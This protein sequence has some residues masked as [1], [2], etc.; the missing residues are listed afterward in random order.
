MT[1]GREGEDG[2]NSPNLGISGEAVIEEE[3]QGRSPTPAPGNDFP[4]ITKRK[5]GTFWRRKSSLGFGS[6]IGVSPQT[7]VNGHEITNGATSGGDSINNARYN[8]LNGGESGTNGIYDG[9]ART[10]GQRNGNISPDAEKAPFRSWSPPPQLPDFIGGGD[11]LG[12]ED[13]FKD[14]H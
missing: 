11:G 5:S 7:G 12:G 1:F 14:I 9:A 3:S 2:V 13:L 4:T 8:G 6:N 10:I